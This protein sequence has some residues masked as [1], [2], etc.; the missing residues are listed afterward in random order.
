MF[1]SMFLLSHFL[2][3]SLVESLFE[4]KAVTK[5]KHPVHKIVVGRLDFI[6]KDITVQ[7]HAFTKKAQEAIEAA[8]GKCE[9]LKAST[10]EVIVA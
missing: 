8:G 6:A 7:A 5:T 4:S 3:Y 10:G 9:L 2:F 1:L